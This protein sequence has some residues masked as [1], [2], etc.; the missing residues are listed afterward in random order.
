MKKP[1]KA[2]KNLTVYKAFYKKC[3]GALLSC[4]M[5]SVYE[6]GVVKKSPLS[7]HDDAFCQ[8]ATVL[9]LRSFVKRHGKREFYAD[10]DKMLKMLKKLGY[11]SVKRGLHSCSTLKGA[12]EYEA[13]E[14]WECAIPEGSLYYRGLGDYA[15]D[16]LLP[17]RKI[18]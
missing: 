8:F 14:V 12:L 7:A 10:V 15:S 5:N 11:V 3:D 9:N 18:C 13:K 4:I 6:H 17:V 2:K 16:A 1:L